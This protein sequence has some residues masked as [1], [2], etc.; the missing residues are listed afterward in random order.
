MKVLIAGANGGTGRNIIQI[1]SESGQHEPVAMI[2]DITQSA[3]L[4]Q[5]GTKETVL[6][7][8][9]GELDHAVEGCDAVIFAAG[10]GSKTG[11]EKT[12]SVDEQG[13][14][15]LIKSA[16]KHGVKRFIMLSTVGADNPEYGSGDMKHY[17][18]SKGKAD[19]ALR[20][21]TLDYTIVRPGA[22]SNDAGN[23]RIQLAEKLGDYNGSIPR[24]DVAKVMSE[25]L[26]YKNT[27]R[28]TFE[29]L[30]GD[31]DITTALKSV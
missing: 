17:F 21:S 23:G 24:E 15:N 18:E 7:D 14:I 28:K 1:L 5:L 8:L 4:E 19:K 13:A 12:V 20:E 16:E 3:E 6:A 30:S 27:S 9:E 26:N 2:R 22:L 25:C 29:I 11:P 31:Q 10:S